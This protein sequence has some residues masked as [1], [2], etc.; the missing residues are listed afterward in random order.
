MTKESM[1]NVNMNSSAGPK[2]RNEDAA[3][4]LYYKN[5]FSI[6]C[7]ADG[8]GGVANGNFAS[9]FVVDKFKS[10]I[11][12]SKCDLAATL[13]LIN[14]ELVYESKKNGMTDQALTTFTGFVADT[15]GQLRGV[16]VGDCRALIFRG[17]G[18]QQLTRDHTEAMR[19]LKNGR[20]TK[21]DFI[22]YP[23][24]HVLD[25]VVGLN[26]ISE[27][28]V[29]DFSLELGDRAVI[30]SDGIYGVMSK[31]SMRDICISS[32]TLTEFVER[33]MADVAATGPKDNF[34]IA[35]V[36]RAS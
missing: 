10:M 36:E 24:K 35:A 16:H 17:Q 22:N 2:I 7:V 4:A 23:R 30:I 1:Y 9:T 34:S 19:L 14:S 27:I 29:F 6:A 31:K 13:K 8:V 15:S 18:V 5:D 26:E 20:L 33:I 21:K 32:V 12:G 25:S 11:E 28:D 3:L